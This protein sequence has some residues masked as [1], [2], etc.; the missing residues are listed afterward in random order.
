VV[1]DGSDADTV[2]AARQQAAAAADVTVIPFIVVV[3]LSL[4]AMLDRTVE[5]W[6]YA[7]NLLVAG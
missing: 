2:V 3:L 4:L 7:L 5:L 1:G 6:R